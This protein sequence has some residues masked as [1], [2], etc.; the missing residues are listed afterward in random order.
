[1]VNENT[2]IGPSFSMQNRLGR[3]LWNCTYILFFRYSPKPLHKWRSF[4]LRCFGARIGKGVHVY[5]AAKIWAP[6][7]V[8]IGDG[9]GVA[10][11]A[12]LYSQGKITIGK[13]AVISQGAH[14]CAGTHDYT[15]KGFILITKPINIG[16]NAWVAA[17]AFVHAGVNIGDGSVIGARSVVTKHM[18]SWMVCSGMPCVPLKA[19]KLKDG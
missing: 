7:N 6:W 15:T 17:E 1:M 11:G 19:R 2:H 9:S 8:E 12:I 5:P 3:L 4:V 18:P 16:D 14:L 13:N 10:N